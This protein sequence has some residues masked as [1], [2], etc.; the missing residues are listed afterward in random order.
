MNDDEKSFFV[1]DK[2]KIHSLP[3]KGFEIAIESVCKVII[4]GQNSNDTI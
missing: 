4:S 1:S 2:I 3:T